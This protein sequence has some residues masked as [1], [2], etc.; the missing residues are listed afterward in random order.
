M[1]MTWHGHGGTVTVPPHLPDAGPSLS[2]GHSPG[3]SPARLAHR[4]WLESPAT[5]PQRRAR[6]ASLM[7]APADDAWTCPRTAV[8]PRSPLTVHVFFGFHGWTNPLTFLRPP[9]REPPRVYDMLVACGVE[10]IRF[11]VYC[12]NIRQE[13]D[14]KLVH[15]A[16]YILVRLRCVR[17]PGSKRHC[18]RV[19]HH[20][21]DHRI[22]AH[23]CHSPGEVPHWRLW[24]TEGVR[25]DPRSGLRPAVQG[26]MPRMDIQQTARCIGS[27]S[28][29][30][31]AEIWAELN[32]FWHEEGL[33]A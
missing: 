33:E 9:S 24:H 2:P 30:T 27:Q 32:A 29:F 5:Y 19:G 26:Y 14:D 17:C 7:R 31:P 11:D 23:P 16:S 18:V 13:E 22:H 4:I 8:K 15:G 6:W 25:T 3:P 28:T 1:T 20:H 12:D 10:G 21:W